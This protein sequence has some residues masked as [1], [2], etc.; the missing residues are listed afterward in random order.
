MSHP[1]FF[2]HRKITVII[3]NAGEYIFSWLFIFAFFL[4]NLDMTSNVT[5]SNSLY[6]WLFY[7][8]YV[9]IHLCLLF[10][11]MSIQFILEI[12]V[13]S[14]KISAFVCKWSV[15]VGLSLVRFRHKFLTQE[16][17]C[18]VIILSVLNNFSSWFLR[19]CLE[20]AW[21][22]SCGHA[23]KQAIMAWAGGRGLGE[24]TFTFKW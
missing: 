10:L 5:G 3:F 12:T 4:W 9:Y 24:Y 18:P 23:L 15:R 7:P 1:N 17:T 6:G 16:Q 8:F 19:C 14:W 2:S 11:I 20:A 13:Q 21:T 22:N